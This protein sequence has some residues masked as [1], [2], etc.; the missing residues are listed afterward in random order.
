MLSLIFIQRNS[1]LAVHILLATRTFTKLLVGTLYFLALMVCLDILL[2]LRNGLADP[3][4]ASSITAS[5][6][7][8]SEIFPFHHPPG[9][10]NG[11]I[12]PGLETFVGAQPLSTTHSSDYTFSLLLFQS[13]II[14]WAP[15][16]EI[17]KSQLHTY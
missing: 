13:R 10:R 2:N 11:N 3:T 17:F 1:C 7:C 8:G 4:L 5:T 9:K 14:P 12:T 15:E 6:C 16:P